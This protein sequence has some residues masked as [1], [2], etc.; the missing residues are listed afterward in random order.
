MY[1]Y[2][3]SLYIS[4]ILIIFPRNIFTMLF[5]CFILFCVLNCTYSE[6][7][8]YCSFYCFWLGIYSVTLLFFPSFLFELGQPA[9]CLLSWPWISSLHSWIF[10]LS[11]FVKERLFHLTF[12]EIME[13]HLLDSLFPEVIHL[14][15]Y[16][17]HLLFAYVSVLFWG[18]EGH[19]WS[20]SRVKEGEQT[21]RKQTHSFLPF[22]LFFF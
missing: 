9:W 16:I 15:M 3:H 7:C 2:L 10:S 8:I 6:H 13:N 22:F 20:R 4:S 5:F 1:L 12:F 18:G 17:F 11:P 21:F 19:L 14:L